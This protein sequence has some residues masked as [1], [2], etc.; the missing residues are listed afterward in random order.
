MKKEELLL[1]ISWFVGVI[2]AARS[3]F[4]LFKIELFLN[5]SRSEKVRGLFGYSNLNECCLDILLFI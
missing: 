1:T 2:P 5:F 3:S 4:I